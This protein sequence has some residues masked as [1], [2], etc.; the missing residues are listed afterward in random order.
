MGRHGEGFHNAAESYYGTPS[1]NVRQLSR[2]EHRTIIL[3]TPTV[4]LV[5]TRRQ[6]NH[7]MG[8]RRPNNRRHQASPNSQRLLARP[9]RHPTRPLPPILLHLT[10]NPLHKNRQ[11]DLLRPRPPRRVP[12]QSHDQ[13]APPRR[14]LH[15]HLRP[16]QQQNIH[17]NP[18]PVLHL[19]AQLP[20][21]RPF[22]VRDRSRDFR[23]S[24][25][26]LQTCSGRPLRA[27]RQLLALHHFAQR[28]DPQSPARSGTQRVLSWDGR[29]DSRSGRGKVGWFELIV[30][31]DA[32]GACVHFDELLH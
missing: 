17:R 10:P 11:P 24:R 25:F 1:W 16:P 29:C 2:R 3:T 12:L 32:D 27:R 23:R 6:R 28:R 31:D 5:R 30:D 13:R 9:H 15:P 19:R 4:L 22:L 18:L 7:H 21:K 20:R 14:N 26:P 8:R